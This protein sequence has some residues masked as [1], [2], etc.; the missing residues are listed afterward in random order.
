[1]DVKINGDT[2]VI[3]IDV[4]AKALKEA[5]PSSTGKTRTVATTHGFSRYQTPAGEVALSLNAS[6]K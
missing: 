6:T 3:T 1:M 4:S 2:M 5:Q